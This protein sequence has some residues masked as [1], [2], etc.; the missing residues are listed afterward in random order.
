M[1]SARHAPA[2]QVLRGNDKA[3]DKAAAS[4]LRWPGVNFMAVDQR[5][6]IW[7]SGMVRC[8][9]ISRYEKRCIIWRTVI[10]KSLILNKKIFHLL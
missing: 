8:R 2:D 9:K 5:F 4:C 1:L 6:I 10:R 3:G 7:N